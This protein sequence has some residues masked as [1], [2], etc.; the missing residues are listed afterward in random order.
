MVAVR[1][2]YE[3]DVWVRGGD[4]AQVQEGF[5]CDWRIISILRST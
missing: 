4:L 2:G 1:D 3:V 5:L